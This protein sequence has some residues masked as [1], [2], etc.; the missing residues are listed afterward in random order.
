MTSEMLMA[1]QNAMFEKR[2]VAELTDVELLDID[3]GTTPVCAVVVKGAVASSTYCVGVGI[4]GGI[5]VV[6]A[7]VGYFAD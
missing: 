2:V 1:K 6:G 7:V 3:G 5:F 4:A